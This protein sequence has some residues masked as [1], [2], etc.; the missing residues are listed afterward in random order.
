MCGEESNDPVHALA[1]PLKLFDVPGRKGEQFGHVLILGLWDIRSMSGNYGALAHN[2]L[3]DR[4]G[5]LAKHSMKTP[6]HPWSFRPRLRARAFGWRGSKL[7]I[8]RLKEALAE[9]GLANRSDPALAAEGAVL[10]MERLWPALQ[11]IDS[12]SGAL[13]DAVG[14]TVHALI[15]I[16]LAAPAEE[17][18]LER[19]LDRLWTA[20]EED[21]VDFLSE[22]GDRWGELCRTASRASRAADGLI[23]AVRLSWSPEHRGYFRGT[24]ACLSCL[25]AAGRHQD[26]L[27][28]IAA[29]PHL[30]WHYRRYGVL[31]L[32]ASGQPDEAIAYAEASRGLNDSPAAIARAGEKVLLAAGRPDE[33]YRRYASL[34]NRAGSH[35][36]TFRAIKKKY[37]AKA[38]RAI[39]DD[40]IAET[41]GEEGKWFATAKTLGLLGLALDLARRSPVDIGTLLRAARDHLDREPAFAL[42]AAT[43]ALGWMAAG[44]FY[45]LR[46]G[47]V[48]QAMGYALRAAEA[49]DRVESTRALIQGV[50]QDP[51][52]DAFVREQL[53]N[54][55]PYVPGR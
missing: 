42:E 1:L 38:P 13:G 53:V 14:K 16:L 50:A 19:W 43:A 10:L 54:G 36:A 31:A 2:R 37:P 18:T 20:M 4:A 45:E 49:L 24:T 33:A 11:G 21:G 40:H 39:L 27:E 29:A 52:T 23:A 41:S 44:Q 35:L 34:A 8:E 9:I 3:A 51:N 25:L 17:P 7:A 6:S 26:L 47:D 12:S 55:T 28:L 30:S 15:D 48:W 32:A 22:V 46:A 5:R